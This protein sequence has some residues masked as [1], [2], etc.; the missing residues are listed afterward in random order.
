LSALITIFSFAFIL[1][2]ILAASVAQSIDPRLTAGDQE[3]IHG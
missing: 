3:S 2:D 1:T